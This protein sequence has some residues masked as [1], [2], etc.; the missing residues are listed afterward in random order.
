MIDLE[1]NV[2]NSGKIPELLTNIF[3][4]DKGAVVAGATARV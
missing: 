4:L 3:N 1:A 2:I